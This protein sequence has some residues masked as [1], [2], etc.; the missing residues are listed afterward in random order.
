MI[1]RLGRTRFTSTLEYL[2]VICVL[3]F[4]GIVLFCLTSNGADAQDPI[5]IEVWIHPGN[6]FPEIMRPIVDKFNA[7]RT[8]IQIELPVV[9]GFNDERVN[10][11]IASGTPP[12]IVDGS[13]GSSD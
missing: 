1:S 10:I 6:D 7:S 13:V 12:D 8:D 5:V 11:A 3:C 4:A 2:R 9:T